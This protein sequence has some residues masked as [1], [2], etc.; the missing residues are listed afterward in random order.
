MTC[1]HRIEESN[2]GCLRAN[3]THSHVAALRDRF[4]T[5]LD[6]HLASKRTFGVVSTSQRSNC[7]L[8]LTLL[9]TL[10]GLG[11]ALNLHSSN[12]L[13]IAVWLVKLYLLV[14]N[15]P[16]RSCT[17]TM[18][19]VHHWKHLVA[20]EEGKGPSI[21]QIGDVISQLVRRYVVVNRVITSR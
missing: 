18:V 15:G 20:C 17:G 11:F 3:K 1:N 21:L 8:V 9:V 7:G 16:Q 6:C 2:G 14:C 19:H 10:E 12:F 4:G 5:C 13:Q